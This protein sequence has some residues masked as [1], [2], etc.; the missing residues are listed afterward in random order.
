MESFFKPVE[1]RWSDLDPN[2]HVRHSVYYD[3]GAYVR[4]CFLTEHGLSTSVLL[5]HQLG[6]ILFREECVFKREIHF[7]DS[8]SINLLLKQCTTTYSRWTMQHEIIKNGETVS[9]IITVDG[10]WLDTARRKLTVPSEF[11]A[12]TFEQL[13][14]AHD[15]KWMDRK[16]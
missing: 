9:A 16:S 2:F 8:V 1:I 7:Q 3:M 5:K 14:R 15:F 13:P 4:M 10:A 6:P 11:V 12:P